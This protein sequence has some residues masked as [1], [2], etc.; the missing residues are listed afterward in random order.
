M[1][2]NID[3]AQGDTIIYE[4]EL[5]TMYDDIIVS[6]SVPLDK[7]CIFKLPNVVLYRC[8]GISACVSARIKVLCNKYLFLGFSEHKSLIMRVID[9]LTGKFLLNR[10]M[11]HVN[12][13][14]DALNIKYEGNDYIFLHWYCGTQH[15]VEIYDQTFELIHY[16]NDDG[17]RVFDQKLISN[18]YVVLSKQGYIR[19]YDFV[20]DKLVFETTNSGCQFIKWKNNFLIYKIGTTVVEIQEIFDNAIWFKNI[21][22]NYM[23]NWT[24]TCILSYVLNF[25]GPYN[26]ANLVCKRWRACEKVYTN[27]NVGRKCNLEVL[28]KN[29]PISFVENLD[30]NNDNINLEILAKFR[31]LKKL[32]IGVCDGDGD[33]RDCSDELMK[34]ISKLELLEKFTFCGYIKYTNENIR[35]LTKLSNLRSLH[36]CNTD[37]K[38][39]IDDEGIKV[40]CTLKSLEELT[41]WG[42]LNVTD[43]GIRMLSNM[44]KLREL[45]IW[46]DNIGDDS[47]RWISNMK[48]LIVLSVRCNK[49]ITD[50]GI[51]M[52]SNMD[53]LRKLSIQTD[54][55]GNDSLRWISNM[56]SLIALDMH[57]DGGEK[58]TDEGITMIGGMDRLEELIIIFQANITNKGL[59]SLGKLKLLR[60]LEI[61]YSNNIGDGGMIGL[62]KM[63]QLEHLVIRN[64]KIT[65]QGMWILSGLKT[66]RTLD[67]HG[68]NKITD[69]GIVLL[70]NIIL[71]EDL[72][73][74]G[75]NKITNKSLRIL[76]GLKMLHALD[77]CDCNKITDEGVASL[78]D[79]I[80]L[81]Y[82]SLRGCNKITNKSLEILRGLNLQHLDISKCV[83]INDEGI[84]LLCTTTQLKNITVGGNAI[85]T[86]NITTLVKTL[87]PDMDVHILPHW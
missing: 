51:R 32:D 24:N 56:K 14:Y 13:L 28:F 34:T 43:E 36:L 47:L 53:N 54:D 41:F 55:I 72:S 67:L 23:L 9:I 69:E 8:D 35:E 57:V 1:K 48:S 52:L 64:Y 26:C 38:E 79:M 71:L 59:I 58:I 7:C 20:N 82:L 70:I 83:N 63:K 12:K 31:S 46:G 60:K 17:Y 75:C 22:G 73:L 19:V 10:K 16:H 25:V 2:W 29:I 77:L 74:S 33:Y 27:I 65:D 21:N 66:L 6:H 11:N 61:T 5:E 18:N 80:L 44:D 39:N 15:H 4:N 86:E 40:L 50:E 84:S 68:C 3:V 49:K 85:S 62:M 37:D 81:K 42:L 76:S 78:I 30:I 45:S 87:R